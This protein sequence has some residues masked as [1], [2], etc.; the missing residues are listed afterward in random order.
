MDIQ[1]LL[2]NIIFLN[3]L[4][5]TIFYWASLIYPNIKIFSTVSKY[6]NVLANLLLFVLLGLR[7]VSFGY[8]PLSNLYESLLFLAWGTTFITIIIENRSK[9]NLIGSIS[10]PIALF[11]TGFASLS[12]P[13][14]MQAPAPLV[15]ALK[16]N[17]LMMHV[18]VMM[19]S[20]A[21]LII[22]S[23]LGIFFL[24][25]AYGKSNRTVLQ[26]N[27]YGTPINNADLVETAFYKTET[28]ENY[29]NLLNTDSQIKLGA[30]T[31]V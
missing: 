26:G 17:W 11:V 25:L 7:W 27:S 18:T 22:G 1:S 12:L 20:Y 28:I 30:Q 21:S 5:L 29:N 14:S 15:P 8:F 4:S 16:S 9:I 24:I 2:D 19:L 6:G 3:L 31:S 13:E 23:L 10:S